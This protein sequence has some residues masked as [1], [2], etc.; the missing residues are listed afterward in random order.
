MPL[1]LAYQYRR[2]LDCLNARRFD[3]LDAFTH[4]TV[5]YN[6]ETKTRAQYAELI[7]QACDAIPDLRF[8]IG[9]LVVEG[10]LVAC[11]LEFRCTPEKP[12][13]GLAPT[14]RRVAFC[15]HVFYRFRED[16]IAEVWSLIDRDSLARQLAG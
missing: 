1:A 15:E 13:M 2:Y 14:G 16:R 11:R 10:D 9:L 12:F 7:A 6:G 5:V 3:A 8:D 4:D